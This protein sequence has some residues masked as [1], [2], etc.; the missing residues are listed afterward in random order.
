MYWVYFYRITR[1]I[2]AFIVN[3]KIYENII[4]KCFTVL[5]S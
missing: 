1:N 2:E 4:I 3:Y 5:K